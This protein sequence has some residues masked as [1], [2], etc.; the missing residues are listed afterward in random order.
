MPGQHS[1]DSRTMTDKHPCDAPR[2]KSPAFG[3]TPEIRRGGVEEVLGVGPNNYSTQE[4]RDP[5]ISPYNEDQ[6][7][8]HQHPE[9]EDSE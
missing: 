2:T 6:V 4:L 1:E 8:D 7:S 3:Y 9:N 5:G